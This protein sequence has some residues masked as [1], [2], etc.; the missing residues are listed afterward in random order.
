[1][2]EYSAQSTHEALKK[3]LLDYIITAYFGKNDDI[4]EL[5]IEEIKRKGVLW[6]EPYIEANAA[7]EVIKNGID[8]NTSLPTDVKKILQSLK[9][10]GLGVYP[11]PYKHQIE[12]LEAFYKGKDL[13]VATGTGSG[14]T[15][16]FMWPL[17]TK[18]IKEAIDKPKSWETR[19]VRT[20]MLYP[21][22]ALVADQI[23][24][25]RKMIGDKDGNFHDLFDELCTDSRYPT[26]GMYTGRTPYA[27]KNSLAKDVDLADTL[28]RDILNRTDEIKKQLIKLGKY[29]SKNSLKTYIDSLRNGDHFTDE[30]DA[31]MIT[32]FEMQ[33]N[34]PDILITNYS[35]LEYMLMRTIE[36]N[37]WKQ[38]QEWLSENKE[39]KLLF[40]IDEAHMYKGASGGEVALL[41]RRFINKMGIS[42]DRVQFI[43]TT[44]SMPSDSYEVIEKFY[45]DLTASDDVKKLHYIKGSKE[46]ISYQGTIDCDPNVLYSFDIANLHKS[47]EERLNAIKEFAKLTKLDTSSCTFLNESEVEQWL[48]RN[49]TK[50]T[51]LL[52]IMEKCR[53]HATPF[54]E[55][56]KVAF[57]NED[58]KISEKA[59]SVILAI[60][61]LAKNKDGQVL[62]P[63]RLHMMFRGLQGVYACSN[64][65]CTEKHIHNNLPIGK[66]YLGVHDDTCKCGG[67]IYELINDRTCG[68][69]FYKG[70]IDETDGSNH[71]IWNKKSALKDDSFKEIH[72]YIIPKNV[73]FKP[74]SKTKT[75]WFNSIS[76]RIERNDNNATKPHYVKLAYSENISKE[77]PKFR[78]LI[79]VLS[80]KKITI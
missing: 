11:S 35:M 4:R 41:I 9:N 36:Q 69:L 76:G 43:L 48:Y 3:R 37:I 34:A 51:P 54:N 39:N 25:L 14:K 68:A 5:C 66:I 53:G 70:Y 17:V 7:Y 42:R 59:T 55:L 40:I 1:M 21:M 67:K 80:A 79:H 78:H 23:G 27:G 28:E 2:E 50:L 16:C 30:L 15:E 6:Q 19:G 18:L 33:K 62:F 13:L 20:I 26:F 73:S 8:N 60:A 57:P 61:P 12:A 32:R 63:S 52:R 44:A 56:V 10:K 75:V 47:N 65:N 58:Y 38:T 45:S 24:R 64:P 71:F 72:Y 77:N 49:L 29:P 22:N 74:S 31:E 46:V